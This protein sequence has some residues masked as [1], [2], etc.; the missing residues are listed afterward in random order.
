MAS[1]TDESEISEMESEEETQESGSTSSVSL[2]T[3]VNIKAAVW[4]YFGMETDEHGVVKDVDLP[5]CKIDGCLTRVKTKHSN[6]SKWRRLS[7]FGH[8]LDVAINKDSRVTRW[9]VNSF[10]Y[11]FS[12]TKY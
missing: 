1:T 7:C 12:T 4:R 6:A 8:N 10:L 9:F 11:F 3:K 5:V 2:V